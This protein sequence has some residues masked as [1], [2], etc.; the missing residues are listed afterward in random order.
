MNYSD[1]REIIRQCVTG[2]AKA[3]L[4]IHHI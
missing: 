3:S 4:N 2:R 1:L